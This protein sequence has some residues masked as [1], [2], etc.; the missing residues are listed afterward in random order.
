M[1]KEIKTL[2]PSI[3]AIAACV[4]LGCAQSSMP[5]DH[6]L[7][8]AGNDGKAGSSSSVTKDVTNGQASGKISKEDFDRMLRSSASAAMSAVQPKLQAMEKL[9]RS[10]MSAGRYDAAIGTYGEER[11]LLVHNGL[12]AVEPDRPEEI[13]CAFQLRQY[14]KV[15]QMAGRSGVRDS[16]SGMAVGIS[17]IKLGSPVKA[18]SYLSAEDMILRFVSNGSYRNFLPGTTNPVQLEASF[19]LARG[20]ALYNT[21]S[22]DEASRELEAANAIMPNQPMVSYFLGS[23]LQHLGR[24]AEAAAFEAP[25]SQMGGPLGHAAAAFGGSI[26]VFQVPKPKP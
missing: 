15:L 9:A 1:N 5:S 10:E 24:T 13:E 16:L 8:Q 22:F 2:L 26:R 25:A 4:S 18:K 17:L 14:Q 3:G 11:A 23:T 12:K 21:M 7:V 20:I 6:P 19:R